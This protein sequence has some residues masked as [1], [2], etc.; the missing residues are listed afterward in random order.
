MENRYVYNEESIRKLYDVSVDTI[1]YI[2]TRDRKQRH[3]SPLTI[4]FL[5]LPALTPFSASP[6]RVSTI[7]PPTDSVVFCNLSSVD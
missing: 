7:L 3:P 1:I 5:H 6:F 2:G 4:S